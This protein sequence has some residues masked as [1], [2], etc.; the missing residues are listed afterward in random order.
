MDTKFQDIKALIFDGY[1]K[2]TVKFEDMVIVI[3]TLSLAEENFVVE[4]YENLP[5]TYNLLAAVETLQRSIYSINGCKITDNSK[6]IV[7]D[8]PKQLIIKLFS[9]YLSLTSRAREATK[10]IDEFIKTDESKLRWSIIRATKTSLNSAIITGN[11][12][13][14]NRGLSYIQ[15]AWVYLNQQDDTLSKNKQA[16]SQIEYMTDSICSF[17]NPK[18]MRQIQGRKQL[19]QEE[20]MLKEQRT[21][22]KEIQSQSK[23]K[24]MIKNTAD[25]LFDSFGRKNG[26][27]MTEYRDRFSKSLVK[28]F[29][30]DEHDRIIREYEEY[31]FAKQLRIQKENARR[32][33]TLHE[34]RKSNVIVIDLPKTNLDVGFHQMTT[35]GDDEQIDAMIKE[36]V[37]TNSYYLN[38]VDYSEIVAITSFIMLKNR[39]KI[40]HEIANES[41]DETMRWIDIYV[42]EENE[43]SDIVAKL[44]EISKNAATGSA[45]GVDAM[46]NR[47]EKVLTGKNRFEEQQSEMIS[48]IQKEN[49]N[50]SDEMYLQS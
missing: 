25:E 4:T 21:E 46:L 22:I 50:D 2:E 30:E 28:A 31:E 5:D 11:Q 20:Q 14:E 38:G 24:I 47:R 33:K 9:S 49:K 37:K 43:K 8:W 29:Q 32:A 45:S 40:L 23:E 17:I 19:Q 6:E 13:F 10:Q 16:W 1:L 39:D 48:D 36:E 7:K 12:E 18:A 35:L 26:E 27:S 42:K 3:R 41:D 34:K 44:N 15:Q